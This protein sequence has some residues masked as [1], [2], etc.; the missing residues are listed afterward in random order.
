MKDIVCNFRKKMPATYRPGPVKNMF[1]DDSAVH[2]GSSALC[3]WEPN[4]ER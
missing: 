1:F 3:K 2:R 4:A